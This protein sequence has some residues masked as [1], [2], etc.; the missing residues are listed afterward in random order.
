MSFK[1]PYEIEWR[2]CVAFDIKRKLL[3]SPWWG[4]KGDDS[5]IQ[6]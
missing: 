5:A 3:A 1:A 2:F 4:R 6:A